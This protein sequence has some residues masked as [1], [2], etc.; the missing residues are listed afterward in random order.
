MNQIEQAG[1]VY[2]ENFKAVT[3]FERAIFLGWYCSYADCEFC[4][5]SKKNITKKAL[6]SVESILAEIIICKS[7]GWIIDFFTSGQDAITI[8]KLIEILKLSSEIYKDDI[9]INIGTLSMDKLKQLKPHVRGVNA[10]IECINPEIQKKVCPSKSMVQMEKMLKNCEELGLD[11]SITIIIGLGETEK[12]MS[13]L[14]DFIK[15]HK[16]S[17]INIYALNPHAY[18]DKKGPKTEYYCA[19]ISYIRIHFPTLKINSG[20]WTDRVGEVDLLLKAGANCIT[21][22][23][24]IKKFNSK[25]AQIIEQKAKQAGREFKGSLTAYQK[26]NI[27]EQIEEVNWKSH[28]KK[29]V[30]QKLYD[31]LK[32]LSQ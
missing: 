20:I 18:T 30:K 24:A 17:R 4:Y 15:K 23:P 21:K 12:D 9:W 16:L 27:D 5:M 14:R 31:Y 11:R 6:R 7:Q 13:K 25:Q 28:I 3:W 2:S 26:I 19:W 8:E 29:G 1:K 10:S 22:F 32:S